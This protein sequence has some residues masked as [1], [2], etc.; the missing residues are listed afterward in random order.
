MS[1][2]NSFIDELKMQLNIVDVIG[3]EVDL[4]KSGANYKGLCPF[5]NEKTPSFVVN[6]E[7]QIFN[8]FGCGEKGDVIKFVQSFYKLS[9]IE[10]VDKLCDE[11]GI[12]KPESMSSKTSIDYNSYYEINAKTGRF[13][14]KNLISENNVGMQYFKKRG[15]SNDTI[16]KFGLG[17]APNSFTSLTDYLKTENIS[18]SDILKLGLANKGE[19]G[20]YDKFRNRVIFPIINTRDKV[21]GF[22]ARAIGDAMPKYLNSSESEIFI[23]KNNLFGLNLT[24]KEISEENRAIIVEG[25]MDVISLYQNG[26]KNVAASLG[27]ALTDNQA[28]LIT[29]YTKNVVLSY[30]SDA[31]GVSAALRGID[32]LTKAGAKVRILTIIDDKDPD[33]FIKKHGREEFNRLVDNAVPAT[34]FKLKVAKRGFDFSN[35]LDV[36]SYIEKIIPILRD[37]G[38]VEQDIY[39]KKIAYEYNVSEHAIGMSVRSDFEHR[40]DYTKKYIRTTEKKSS[41]HVD[42]K[43]ELSFLVLALNN[44]SYISRIEK[45]GIEFY[46]DLAKKLFANQLSLIND[47]ER[48]IHRID[49]NDIIKT[50]DPDDENLFMKYLD[51]IHI[52]SDDEE[53]YQRTLAAYKINRYK[54]EKAELLNNLAIAEIMNQSEEMKKLASRLIELDKLINK[55]MEESHA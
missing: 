26:V 3:R 13:F 22:G 25:Y 20:L 18:E 54:D 37:L 43:I 48:V 21:V 31:A 28:K 42:L 14:Y 44:T 1:W 35:N 53:F 8:C 7:K 23:K 38:P 15:L 32:V 12:K 36:L 41:L 30:D 45:D 19:K 33:D 16:V 5:H 55:F 40:N 24:K 49:S 10:A 9:F 17:Y 11:Y 47:N 29:R 51:T 2:N 39:I 4:R 46:T 34:D 27:T 50:L 52:G 6:E